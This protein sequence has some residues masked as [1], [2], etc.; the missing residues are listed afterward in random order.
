MLS[1]ENA[2]RNVATSSDQLKKLLVTSDPVISSFR[3]PRTK[4]D[5]ISEEMKSLL[6]DQEKKVGRPKKTYAESSKCTQRRIVSDTV[7]SSTSGQ[8]LGIACAKKLKQEGKKDA[9]Q[10]VLGACKNAKDMQEKLDRGNKFKDVQNYSPDEALSLKIS[11]G[12]SQEKYRSMRM[13]MVSKGL[14]DMYPTRAKI[15]EAEA[16]CLPHPSALSVSESCA[17]VTLQGLLDHTAARLVN[18]LEGEAESHR[19]PAY[20]LSVL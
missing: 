1:Q 7:K 9:A 3:V 20:N 14:P 13:G 12:L 17:E 2:I 10:L 6:V 5:V 16:R 4:H 18:M 19:Y 8:A 15:D 11:L